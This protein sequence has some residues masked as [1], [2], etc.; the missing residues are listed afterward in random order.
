MLQP[1]AIQHLKQRLANAFCA[2][3]KRVGADGGER[4]ALAREL[5]WPPLS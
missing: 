5:D 1:A 3:W 2:R 4:I